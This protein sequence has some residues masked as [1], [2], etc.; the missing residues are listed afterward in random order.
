MVSAYGIAVSGCETA[1]SESMYTQGWV[2]YYLGFDPV[3]ASGRSEFLVVAADT[4]SGP[5][6]GR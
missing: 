4:G 6:R 1:G 5:A 3:F 2:T